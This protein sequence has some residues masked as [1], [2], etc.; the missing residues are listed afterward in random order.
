MHLWDYFQL[1]IHIHIGGN[2]FGSGT[3]C[4]CVLMLVSGRAAALLTDVLLIVCGQQWSS[5]AQR[6]QICHIYEAALGC[7]SGSV[8]S[9]L[10]IRKTQNIRTNINLTFLSQHQHDELMKPQEAAQLLSHA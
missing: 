5:V 10:V 2:I 3:V 1:R 4:V 8:R 9:A 7:R 6:K